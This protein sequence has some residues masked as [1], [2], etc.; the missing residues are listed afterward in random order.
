M[1]QQLQV[2]ELELASGDSPDLKF[3]K[4]T[5]AHKVSIIL[6]IV[7]TNAGLTC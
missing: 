3:E 1:E 2:Q 6:S 4:L 5:R 7:V